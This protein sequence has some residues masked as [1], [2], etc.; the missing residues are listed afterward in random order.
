MR[1]MMDGGARTLELR[2]PVG[3]DGSSG[4]RGVAGGQ[5]DGDQG[6]SRS[7]RLGKEKAKTQT[8]YARFPSF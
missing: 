5:L 7:Q 3:N 8:F 2:L 6:G 1:A 4:T